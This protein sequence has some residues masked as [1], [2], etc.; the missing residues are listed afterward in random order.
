ME[1]KL[2]DTY[3][4]LSA[5]AASLIV[6]TIKKKHDAVLCFASGDTPKR[7]YELVAEIAKKEK[8]D[9]SKCILIGLD[10]WLGVPPDN[11]G[12][13]HYF[14]QRY[15]IK[16]LGLHSKQVYLFDGLTTDG[17]VECEKMNQLIAEKGKIDFMLVGVGMNGHIGFNEP[18]T[19]VN[20]LTHVSKLSNITVTI[21]QKYFTDAMP[22][23]KGITIGLRQ[24]MASGTLLMMANGKKKA[25]VISRVVEGEI[26]NEFP[27]SL[28]RQHP[29]SILMVDKE[30]AFELKT[31]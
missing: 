3:E 30:A 12:S 22:I 14:L 19:D 5:A 28:L 16:P 2:F 7:A 26:T 13:C 27:A 8:V 20:S 18:C 9:F 23:N 4:T 15:L 6:D 21:G 29:N 24:V 11:P 17:E 1:L 25:P 10:E 31:N